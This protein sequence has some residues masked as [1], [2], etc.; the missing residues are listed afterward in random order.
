MASLEE[1]RDIHADGYLG[2]SGSA[3][4]GFREHQCSQVIGT[5]LHGRDFRQG[6][7]LAPYDQFQGAYA[8][9][10]ERPAPHKFTGQCVPSLASGDQGTD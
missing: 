7:Y 6:T 3:F 1:G 5:V 4:G 8:R 10:I 2:K 9:C